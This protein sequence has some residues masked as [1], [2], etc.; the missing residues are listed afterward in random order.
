MKSI[1]SRLPPFLAAA[2]CA[3]ATA[4]MAQMCTLPEQITAPQVR[5]P[6]YRNPDVGT[7]YH[8]FVLSWSPEHCAAQ[9]TPAQRAKHK[10]QC[11]LNSFEFVVHGLW[12][13]SA[14]ASNSRQHPRHCKDASALD[15]E[16][17]KAHLC[18]VPG[19][20]LMQNEWQAHGTCGWDAPEDYFS[21]IELEYERY[22]K[23]AYASFVSANGS[24]TVGDL[25]AAFANASPGLLSPD[26]VAVFVA[27][28]SPQRLQEVWICLDVDFQPT[29][30]R[31]AGAP[32][33]QRIVVRK[34]K[35]H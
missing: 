13:Q 30:C 6:D 14:S 11:Q 3:T 10:F 22:A 9:K 21:R 27:K 33:T 35:A 19:A 28:G 32:D 24:T 1:L 8:A 34:P 31:G 20:D 5:A 2:L 25:K 4:S 12:P 23:P 29:D 16:I 17:V 26:Q 18:T 15:A 7:D